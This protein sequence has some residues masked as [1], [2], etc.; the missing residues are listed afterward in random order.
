ME[1]I[2][3]EITSSDYYTVFAGKIYFI[4]RIDNKFN[5]VSF[6]LKDNKVYRYSLLSDRLGKFRKIEPEGVNALVDNIS[7]FSINEDE[8]CFTI[9][10]GYKDKDEIIR[11]IA[12]RSRLYE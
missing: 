1:Y 7:S 3:D 4:Q 8:D 5:Y 10:I 11:R 12:K 6:G 9:K 2:K